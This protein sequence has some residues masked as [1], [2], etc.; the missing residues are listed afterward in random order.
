MSIQRGLEESE[1]VEMRSWFDMARA[2]GRFD[3]SNVVR[4]NEEHPGSAGR[5]LGRVWKDLDPD[6]PDR[7]RMW[8]RIFIDS[9]DSLLVDSLDP[10]LDHAYSLAPLPARAE[11]IAGEWSIISAP[12]HSARPRNQEI[13]R[14]EGTI[15]SPRWRK[16]LVDHIIV[17]LSISLAV[18]TF[19]GGGA[20]ALYH[21]GRNP[22]EEITTNSAVVPEKTQGKIPGSPS[23]TTREKWNAA[24]ALVKDTLKNP[25]AKKNLKRKVDNKSLNS[26]EDLDDAAAYNVY[27]KL[28]EAPSD[29]D[30][31]NKS[32]NYTL[33][34]LI[35]GYRQDNPQPS[36]EPTVVAFLARLLESDTA[37]RVA[38]GESLQLDIES[39]IESLCIRFGVKFKDAD[40]VEMLESL[41][42]MLGPM[43]RSQDGEASE[44][45]WVNELRTKLDEEYPK[46]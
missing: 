20:V 37:P 22:S 15:F 12:E 31:G 5:L 34:H 9:L 33:K 8:A 18:G 25:W 32:S 13:Q 19:I 24:L 36:N 45:R 6:Q 40:R 1:A 7:S 38:S 27:F 41:L 29:Y 23:P 43:Y 30:L 11:E 14:R 21:R 10:L 44:F 4:L 17:F 42:K 2:Q 26:I 28:F 3:G 16:T 35:K 39:K 46:R